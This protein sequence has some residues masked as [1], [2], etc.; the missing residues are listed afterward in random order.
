MPTPSRFPNLRL[1]AVAAFAATIVGSAACA[2]PESKAAAA[3]SGMMGNP[4]MS[5]TAMG[6][7]MAPMG[8]ATGDA[9]RDFLRAMSDHHKGLIAMVH[10]NVEKAGDHT[11]K[12]DARMLD[13]AQD[14][15]LDSM[16]TM[17]EQQYKDPYA[18][19]VMPEH[20]AMVDSLAAL[21]GAAYDR[22][23]YADV[24]KHHR[25]AVLMVDQYAPKLTQPMLRS[26]AADMKSRQTAEIADFQ[27]K[28]AALE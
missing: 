1:V 18:P 8:G 12:A 5:G 26:M 19:K 28:L 11:S 21:A 25:E 16:T 13:A 27:R 14:R 3:D 22:R 20:Q 2:K 4:A 7:M 15:E 24:I 17:L 6:G 10:Q 23:F 9:N